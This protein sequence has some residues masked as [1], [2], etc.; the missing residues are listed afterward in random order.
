MSW[1]RIE[2]VGRAVATTL[3]AS[4]VTMAPPPW[5]SSAAAEMRGRYALR[6]PLVTV[7]APRA[8]LRL[9]LATLVMEDA[10]LRCV[11]ALPRHGGMLRPLN[12]SARP[13]RFGPHFLYAHVDE[14]GIG[15]GY[16]VTRVVRDAPR[17]PSSTMHGTQTPWSLGDA[18]FV[19]DVPAGEAV[20]DGLLPGARVRILASAQQLRLEP[21]HSVPAPLPCRGPVEL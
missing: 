1:M 10:A 2:T 14:V 4:V 16:R 5:H 17:Y 8:R 7:I 11:A 12:S 3:L 21:D 13:L 9:R 18:R 6:G 19:I 15:S 20:P